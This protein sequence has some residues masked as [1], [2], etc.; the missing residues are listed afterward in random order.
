MP[1]T[2]YS[3]P[4]CGCDF[5]HGFECFDV[6]KECVHYQIAKMVSGEVTE[7]LNYIDHPEEK[8]NHEH[9]C[10]NRKQRNA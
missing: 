10:R 9:I 2:T 3:E 5:V 6:C 1:I 4:Y 8:D 7:L